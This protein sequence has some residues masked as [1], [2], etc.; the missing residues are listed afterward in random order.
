VWFGET[1]DAREMVQAE[2]RIKGWTRAKKVAL[3]E[4]MN[5]RWR[6]LAADWFKPLR[7]SK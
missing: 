4:S 5:P 2:R 3:I 1:N 7:V 6:D